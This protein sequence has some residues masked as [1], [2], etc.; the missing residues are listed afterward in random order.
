MRFRWADCELDRE[1]RSLARAGRPVPVQKLVLDLLLLL[2]QYRS[3]IVA[4]DVLHRA[5]WPGVR[6]SDSSVRRLLKE[7]RRAIGDDG[8][9]QE[10]IKTIRGRGVLFAAPVKVEEG[11]DTSF[12]GRRDLLAEL[13]GTL[14]GVSDGRGAVTL[15]IGP[16]G[17]GK[18]R[19]LAE[20]AARA[21]ARGFLVRSGSG[22]AG[23]IGE[24]FHPWLDAAEELG[25]GELLRESA[26]APSRNA[27]PELR[28]ARFRE[29]SRELAQRATERPL[30]LTLD[31]LQFA[32][33]DSLALMRFIAPAL[34]FTRVWL[35]GSF[36]SAA[37]IGDD[38]RLRDLR[39]LAAE[40][41]SQVVSMRR[42]A[43]DELGALVAAQLGVELAEKVAE[44]LCARTE[45]NPFFALELA[46]RL[47]AEGRL[48]REGLSAEPG[49]GVALEIDALLA[50]RAAALTPAARRLLRAAAALGVEFD[51]R[52]LREAEG[53]AQRALA[54]ALAEATAAG[55]LDPAGAETRRFA[56]PLLAEALYAALGNDAPA[57]HL[58]LAEALE[59]LG[60]GD[61][62]VLAR[63]F[64][65]S[66]PVVSAE[67]ALP[68]ARAA[69]EEARRRS[70]IA[71][72]E[73]WYGHAVELA[74]QAGSREVGEL[75]LALGE[76]VA[77]SAW[78]DAARPIWQR[79]VRMALAESDPVLLARAALA[80][81]HRPDLL[82]AQPAI[83]EELRAA[84]DRPS[85]DVSLEARV[86]SRLGAELVAAGRE[87]AAA[88]A[89]LLREGEERAR[90]LGDPFTLA[91][92][93]F[94]VNAASFPPLDPRGRLARSE[95]VVRLAQRSGDLE[96][97]FRG[98]CS[99]VFAH[100]QL[101]ERTAAQQVLESCQRLTLEHDLDYARV[102]THTIEASFATLDGRFADARA[103]TDAAEASTR[104]STGTMLTL[105][106]QR[107]VLALHLGEI[108]GLVSG[109]Q[110][111]RARFPAMSIVVGALALAQVLAGDLEAAMAGLERIVSGLAEIPRDWSWLP[112]LLF[113]SE[114]AFRARAPIAAATLQ[115][116]LAPFAELHAVAL[117]ASMYFG[118]VSQG[119]G[120]LAAARG[121]SAEAVAWFRKA[122]EAHT[123]M[124]SPPWCERSRR[125]I[126]EVQTTRRAR[127]V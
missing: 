19:T 102:L 34:R 86:A 43:A 89:A 77:A 16:A 52:V 55:L 75:M 98:L 106:G 103:A 71:N 56:H 67:R 24:A 107:L 20:L 113:A 8:A 125:A 85:G 5:L 49:G 14:E 80:H 69:A 65:A 94:D 118:A 79:V 11:W 117:N 40:T 90:A 123:A 51:P 108:G 4:E 32:D 68:Y 58:R 63:H 95:E 57:Q 45:G 122:L 6:V 83:L 36:R 64:V 88:G 7:A 54:Q 37:G 127:A 42:L 46:R 10:Q 110:A 126:A 92:V 116:E 17:I 96:L 27:E 12:V 61:P 3:R 115:G 109:L 23:A 70:A 121:R 18:T 73:L 78:V 59:R 26:R 93:L 82:G 99:C 120:W 13:E 2:L 100:T 74:Q 25:I 38:P 39:V 105:A 15:L 72:A 81:A 124:R 41:S 76:V 22:R 66:R 112:T 50:R 29:V 119:L 111:T 30:L 31:D 104:E 97:R 91:R 114:V 47:R 1:T 9:K 62:F 60:H 84:R 87:H 53:V 21:E 35:L 48:T 44:P 33:P 101:G 28:R